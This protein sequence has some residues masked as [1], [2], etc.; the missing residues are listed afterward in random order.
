MLIVTVLFLILCLT[1]ISHPTDSHQHH[2]TSLWDHVVSMKQI[3]VSIEY[4]G[5]QLHVWREHKHGY[6]RY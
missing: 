4:E 5:R 3:I 6:D 1:Q 2:Q